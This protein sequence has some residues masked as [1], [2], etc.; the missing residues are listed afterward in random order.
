MQNRPK[1]QPRRLRKPMRPKKLA[2]SILGAYRHREMMRQPH[3]H[4]LSTA[5]HEPSWQFIQ[6]RFSTVP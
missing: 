4:P 6:D 2:P 1:R 5:T 3:N